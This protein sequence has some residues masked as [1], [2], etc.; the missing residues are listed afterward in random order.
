[1][2]RI[3]LIAIGVYYVLIGGYMWFAPLTWYSRTPGV[4]DTGPFNMHFVMDIALIFAVAGGA[5][6]FGVIRRNRT[7]CA[8]GAIWPGLHAAFHIWIWITRG[9]P[10]D[11]VAL[12]NLLGIQF[13]AWLAVLAIL[14][15]FKSEDIR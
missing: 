12:A 5:M 15:L 2:W 14:K 13:P 7:A 10:G 8:I 11:P 3:L 1:M 9:M 4:S 6:L